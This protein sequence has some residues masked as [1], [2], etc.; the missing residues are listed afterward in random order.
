MD[1]SYDLECGITNLGGCIASILYVFWEASAWVA[2]LAGSFLD[3]F[4]YYSTNSDSYTSIFI[5]KAWSIIRDI[6]N[7]FFIIA[8]LYIAIKTILSLNVTNNKKLIGAIVVVAL[9]INFSMFFTEVIIDGSNILAKVFYNQ[10]KSVNEN[11]EALDPGAGG[12]KSISVG[13]V[14]GFNPQN[15]VKVGAYNQKGGTSM[16]IF[17]T[18]MLLFLTLYTAYMFFV[19]AILFIGR[20]ISLWLAMI[21]SPLAFAS[22]TVPFNI[23]GFGYKKWWEDLLKAAFLAPIFIFFLYVIAL[24]SELT[25]GA[26]EYA[27][28]SSDLI[29]VIMKTLIP[30]SIIFILL[31]QAKKLAVDFSGDLGKALSKF[32]GMALGFA[33][34][35]VMG[36]A[37]ML[38]TGVVG[39]VA[40][41]LAGSEKLQQATKEKGLAGWGARMALRT[42]NL[43]QK[44]TFD[45]RKTAVGGAMAR[46][47]G[48]DFQK[49]A[50][51]LGLGPK[52]GGFKGQIE[53]KVKK[54][55]EESELLK[56][57]MTD[58][59][60]R[61]WSAKKMYE[62]DARRNEAIK[63]AG[64]IE[65]FNEA[66][67]KKKNGE[68]P[69]DYQTAEALDND[70]LRAFAENIGKT[71]LIYSLAHTLAK[72]A[73]PIS[74]QDVEKAREKYLEDRKVAKT[75][76]EKKQGIT[77][78]EEQEELFNKAYA[79][80]RDAYGRKIGE[81]PTME[82]MMENRTQN[83][84]M[85]LATA[86]TVGT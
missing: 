69:K 16:F 45:V 34:G 32:G 50:S 44:A 71:S 47:M 58:E 42:V 2:R 57:R 10:I 20:V 19:V 48:V 85:G 25:K 31:M 65:K 77:F 67:F 82:S 49:S 13:L 3:F 81:I 22:Y 40:S 74:K 33:G 72:N 11:G 60:V 27:S 5:T 4:V 51:I 1:S 46:G 52:A 64:G 56:T 55:Q 73:A 6:A 12:Q 14:R 37:A 61:A 78:N 76:A 15:I 23:P 9:L 35:A 70:K 26:F 59:E 36:G 17:I 83:I 28:T 54:A 63:N 21:F 43:G 38:G 7:I 18:I 39:G 79:E 86:A 80:K 30:F 41:R 8:L 66:E 24:F 29:Q 75:E 84:K 68:R 53:R 62:Y